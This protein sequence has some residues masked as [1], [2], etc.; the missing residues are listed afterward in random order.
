M[1]AERSKAKDNEMEQGGVFGSGAEDNKTELSRV[2]G[3]GAEYNETE[4]SRVF[5]SGAERKIMKWRGA[6]GLEAGRGLR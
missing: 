6:E 2:Y 3:R 1:E 4:R 5:G